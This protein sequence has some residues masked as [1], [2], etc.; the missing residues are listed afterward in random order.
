MQGDKQMFKK[1]IC[2]ALSAPIIFFVSIQSSMANNLNFSLVDSKKKPLAN[3]AIYVMPLDA[4]AK[5]QTSNKKGSITQRNKTYIPH[6]SIF[7]KGTNVT[8][9]NE[10]R[11]K[12]H[13]YSFSKAKKFEIK[14]Y[15]GKPPKKIIFDKSGLVTLGCNI[16]D[17]MLAYAYILDTPYYALSNKQGRATLRNVPNGQY[18]L[19]IEHPQQKNEAAIQKRLNLSG[20]GRS[21]SYQ[22]ALKPKWKQAGQRQPSLSSAYDD[23]DEY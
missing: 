14:L 18:L 21:F 12:H 17:N 9:L 7:Q 8:F 13:V 2:Y 15:S 3:V 19:K 1:I 4:S 23:E 11:K 6:V 5:S 20:K 10:D 22:L 16:H